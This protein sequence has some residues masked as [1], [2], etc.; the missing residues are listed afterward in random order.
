M[1]RSCPCFSNSIANFT[2]ILRAICALA[3]STS[4]LLQTASA[5][6]S[7][8]L[9]RTRQSLCCFNISPGP[10]RS[11]SLSST[12]QTRDGH[13]GTVLRSVPL[14][15]IQPHFHAFDAANFSSDGLLRF[16]ESE[17]L[18][19]ESSW[20]EIFSLTSMGTMRARWTSR[21]SLKLAGIRNGV[22]CPALSR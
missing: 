7:L 22:G 19:E 18:V 16:L 20:K 17:L 3:I 10:R 12:F 13:V 8:H 11:L 14:F 6:C 21:T 2:C 5:D 4:T 15:L 9:S 1:K